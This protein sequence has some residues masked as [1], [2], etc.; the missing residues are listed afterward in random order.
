MATME[1]RRDEKSGRADAKFQ[2]MF[3]SVMVSSPGVYE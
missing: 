3:A 2:E 1:R